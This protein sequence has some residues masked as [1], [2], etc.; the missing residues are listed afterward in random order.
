MV[1]AN[2]KGVKPKIITN[3]FNG[4]FYDYMPTWYRDIG[5]KLVMTMLINSIMPY[6]DLVVAFI[7]PKVF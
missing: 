3:N 5:Q 1:N 2:F 4:P 6:I 7:T